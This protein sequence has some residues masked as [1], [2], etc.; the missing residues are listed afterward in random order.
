MLIPTTIIHIV[1]SDP[2]PYDKVP[3]FVLDTDFGIYS[4]YGTHPVRGGDALLYIGRARGGSFGWRVPQHEWQLDSNVV[5]EVRVQLGRLAGIA[6]PPDDAWNRQIDLAERL[7]I[8][9]H[10]P[11]L[12]Q[13]LGLGSL[14]PELQS[15]HVCNWGVRGDILPE[16]S[17]LRW[18]TTGEAM[19]K[20]LYSTKG[21]DDENATP[22]S[23]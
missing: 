6:T 8:F 14:E 17:G 1:W 5:G 22:G 12:N 3:E 23:A 18:T 21:R 15:V 20:N 2:I 11:P 16:V 7:L 4:I 19:P 9:A 13:R 10:Q